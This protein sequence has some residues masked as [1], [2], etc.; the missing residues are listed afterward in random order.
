MRLRFPRVSEPAP[1]FTL[2]SVNGGQL[3]LADITPP[4]ALVFLRHLG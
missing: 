4:V 2:P 1:D 3:H